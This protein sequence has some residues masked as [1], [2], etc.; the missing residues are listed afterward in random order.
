MTHIMTYSN[1]KMSKNHQQTYGNILMLICQLALKIQ[2]E[3]RIDI[4]KITIPKV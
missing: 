4:V 3:K 1:S 2:Y